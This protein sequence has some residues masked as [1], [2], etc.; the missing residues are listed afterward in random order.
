[1]A[2]GFLFA[3]WEKGP[4]LLCSSQP[5]LIIPVADIAKDILSQ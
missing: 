1:M 5:V 2:V 3:L 4:I